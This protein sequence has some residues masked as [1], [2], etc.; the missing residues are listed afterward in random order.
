MIYYVEN[1]DEKEFYSGAFLNCFIEAENESAALKGTK[2]YAEEQGWIFKCLKEI[3]AAERDT[4]SDED[5][6]EIYDEA[7]EYGVSGIFYTW[8]EQQ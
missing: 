6:L 7:R 2:E 4:Y 8:S 5:M 1:N 3:S